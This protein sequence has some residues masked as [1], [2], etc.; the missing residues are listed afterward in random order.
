M[1]C[2]KCGCD[3]FINDGDMMVCA[4]CG[5]VTVDIGLDLNK[6]VTNQINEIEIETGTA[7]DEIQAPPPIEEVIAVQQA[8]IEAES[9]K[10]EI[11]ADIP[12][13]SEE[14]AEETKGKKKAK[15]KKEKDKKREIIEF[16]IPIIIAAILA[17]IIKLF[18]LA[19]AVVPTGSMI[20]T[21]N[22]KDRIIASRLAYIS[23]DPERYDIILF[24]FPD[25]EETIFVKRV[26]GC[27]GEI[28]NV[29]DGKVYITD[30]T[31]NEFDAEDN[32]VNQAEPPVGTS[33][34]FYIPKQGEKITTDG[35]YCYAEN[36]MKVGS[37]SFLSKYCE[38]KDG[39]Y[40]VKE[41]LYFCIGDNINT[42]M[43]SR[44]WANKYVSESKIIGKAIFKYYPSF[45]K[46]K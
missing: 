20:P 2:K 41:N 42:S 46:L 31:G 17:A 15:K 32:F 10:A 40:Y 19:N 44:A 9:K 24:R 21:I 45:E 33:G 16:F 8:E 43:D 29:R 6:S 3:T 7:S 35:S 5:A 27:P 36:E 13:E 30:E 22:E 4:Q 12:Q 11:E 23:N 26:L 14:N 39:E 38:E 18:I 25:N 37:T 1:I 28:I 34:P